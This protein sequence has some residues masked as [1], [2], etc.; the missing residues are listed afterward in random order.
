MKPSR[1]LTAGAKIFFENSK[2]FAFVLADEGKTKIIRFS[3]NGKMRDCWQRLGAIPLPPYIRRKAEA[4]DK[5]RFL[6]IASS[7]WQTG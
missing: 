4:F 3:G 5:Q 2:T 6:D 1:K 7:R